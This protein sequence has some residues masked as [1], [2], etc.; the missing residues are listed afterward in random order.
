MT[1]APTDLMEVRRELMAVTG[2]SGDAVGIVGDPAHAA[3]GGYHEGND[4]LARVGRLTTDYSKKH[5]A[6]DRPGS[7]AASALDVGDG[8]KRG[9]GLRTWSL[10]LVAAMTANERG[11]LD[12]R[13]IIYTPD[14]KTVKRLDREGKS[15][16]GDKSHLWHTHIS[17]YRDSE[18]RRD[19]EFK[20]LALRL[21]TGEDDMSGYGYPDQQMPVAEAFRM[22]ALMSGSKQVRG[23]PRA[24][25]P[26]WLVIEVDKI[27][28][29]V[30]ALAAKL[31]Q[32]AKTPPVVAAPSPE[33]MKVLTDA[34]LAA[35]AGQVDQAV[36][37]IFADAA[38]EDGP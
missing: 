37:A 26:M 12:I 9:V 28:T 33:Q 31:D 24:G 16:T 21:A 19:G 36:R 23:G 18:G 1:Y 7:N 8:W 22:D 14:G 11:T 20:A 29:D 5:S 32:L 13:E 2:L 10:A 4:D 17:F 38:K 35:V 30:A 27:A 6:R 34:L 15:T 3:T 25:E